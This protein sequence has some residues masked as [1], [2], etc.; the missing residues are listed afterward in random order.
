VLFALAFDPIFVLAAVVRQAFGDFVKSACCAAL[1]F[2]IR[3]E[4]H[5][6]PDV[7][8]VHGLLR[9]APHRPKESPGVKAI[10]IRSE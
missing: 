1:V 5:E 2:S 6:L 9:F 7:E 10:R 8:F 3:V 4:L